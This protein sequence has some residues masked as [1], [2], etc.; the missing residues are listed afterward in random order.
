MSATY[1]LQVDRSGEFPVVTVSH[2]GRNVDVRTIKTL[3]DCMGLGRL[4][5]DPMTSRLP[6]HEPLA[7]PDDRSTPVRMA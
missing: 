6:V 1:T 3:G 2:Q 5:V 7:P 4:L